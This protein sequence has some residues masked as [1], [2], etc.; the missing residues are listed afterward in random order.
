MNMKEIVHEKF[1]L[2]RP[3][4]RPE[5][6]LKIN[7]TEITFVKDSKYAE[8]KRTDIDIDELMYELAIIKMQI[9]HIED[10]YR[11]VLRSYTHYSKSLTKIEVEHLAKKNQ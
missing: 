4:N 5:V 10:Y 6:F 11:I 9:H 8:V 1:L 3:E 2:A 7:D